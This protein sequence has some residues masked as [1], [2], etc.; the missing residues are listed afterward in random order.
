MVILSDMSDVAHGPFAAVPGSHKANLR[1]PFEM[2]DARQHPLAV[3]VLCSAGDV[4]IFSEG[5]THNAFPVLS[6]T[7][8]RS[9]FFCHMPSIDRDNLPG[10]RMS[11]YPEHV[12]KRLPDCLDKLT[13]SG[14]I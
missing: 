12:L 9:I 6:R 1:C 4:I 10:M 5:M 8:R 3:P 14:Y 7:R 13:L 2:S 11:M